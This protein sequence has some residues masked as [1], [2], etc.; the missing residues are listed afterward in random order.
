MNIELPFLS[1]LPPDVSLFL[2]RILMLLVVLI[3]VWVL[4]RTVASL[5]LRPLIALASRSDTELDDIL[6]KA[7]T[8]PIRLL[9]IAIAILL[10]INILDVGDDLRIFADN[11]ARALLVATVTFAIYNTVSAISVTPSALNRITG[12]TLE[13]RLLPFFETVVKV[14]IVVMGGLIILQEFGYNVT[15]LIASFGI[16]G[17]A[18]SLAAQD[19][20]ANVFGFITIVSDNPFK[21]GDFIVTSEFSG[22]VETVG[23][24]AT[25]VRKL[26]QSLVT[27]P[28]NFLM[29]KPVT[30]WSRLQRR[31]LDFHL[32]VTYTTN[33]DQMLALTH[34]IRE[35]LKLR[36]LVDPE[37]V[38]VHFTTFNDSSLDLRIV[39]GILVPDFNGYTAEVELINLEIMRIVEALGLS[40]AFPSTSLYVEAVPRLRTEN[41]VPTPYTAPVPPMDVTPSDVPDQANESASSDSPDD[42]EV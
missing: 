27:V 14:F 37:S 36:E 32:G 8:G 24:R 7:A 26:D 31:R 2:V 19:T 21:V 40:V 41:H 38:L 29:N 20:A 35:M 33:A 30:N 12:V 42:Q 5:M 17:L 10:S 16:V 1:D 25:R 11:V 9:V 39:A 4:R 28:N 22:I 13:E 34:E 15:G 6:I 23:V 3:L 18:F